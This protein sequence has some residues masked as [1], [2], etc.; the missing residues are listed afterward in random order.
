MNDKFK[1]R[2]FI[3]ALALIAGAT[4]L[5]ALDKISAEQWLDYS[6]LLG[7]GY[8]GANVVEKVGLKMR[9]S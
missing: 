1:S 7:L 9:G 2:K 5:T 3:V 6:Q 4:V 8:L